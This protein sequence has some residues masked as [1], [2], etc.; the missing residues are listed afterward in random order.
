EFQELK[1]HLL[2]FYQKNQA[3]DSLIPEIP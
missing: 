3:N 1:N 2:D